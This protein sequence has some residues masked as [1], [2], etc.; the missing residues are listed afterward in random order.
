LGGRSITPSG[1][2]GGSDARADAK[3]GKAKGRWSLGGLS[4]LGD[5]MGSMGTALGL[6]GPSSSRGDQTLRNGPSSTVHSAPSGTLMNGITATDLN[7]GFN[8]L[9]VSHIGE[10]DTTILGQDVET[11]EVEQSP[12]DMPDLQ[13]A[14]QAEYIEELG[15]E[16]RS[17]WISGNGEWQK[18]RIL[19]VIVS[20]ITKSLPNLATYA[21]IA[22]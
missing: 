19:W 9:T 13:A 5:V 2:V 20:D 18:R 1:D 15:W 22:G 21:I 3:P 14:V 17:V 8:T 16:G 11:D 6:A 12:V 10:D 7:H 4:G